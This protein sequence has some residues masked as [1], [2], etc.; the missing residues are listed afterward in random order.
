MANSKNKYNRVASD[1]SQLQQF[2]DEVCDKCLDAE[3]VSGVKLYRHIIKTDSY[4]SGTIYFLDE[5]QVQTE[6]PQQYATK[7]ELR[8]VNFRKEP[9]DVLSDILLEKDSMVSGVIYN[10]TGRSYY[11]VS[12]LGGISDLG[13]VTNA[14]NDTLSLISKVSLAGAQID[15]DTVTEL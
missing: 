15:T 12:I 4:L 10:G 5:G 11:I 6:T 7:A 8:I 9:Y 13:V 3:P 1:A 14:S 2:T